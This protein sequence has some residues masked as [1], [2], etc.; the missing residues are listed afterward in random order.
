VRRRKVRDKDSAYRS[1]Q[2]IALQNAA[3]S[4]G[5]DLGDYYPHDQALLDD[6]QEGVGG[7]GRLDASR[8]ELLAYIE[9][10]RTRRREQRRARGLRVV[11][12]CLLV[13]AVAL[14]VDDAEH[15][16]FF[17][18]GGEG[19]TRKDT[20]NARPRLPPSVGSERGIPE[21]IQTSVS[22]S[23]SNGDHKV[24]YVAYVD[25]FGDVCPTVSLVDGGI[26][27]QP[28]GGGCSRLEL[29]AETLSHEPAMLM[30]S[31]GGDTYLQM[32]GYA[33]PDL[34]RLIVRGHTK[35]AKVAISRAW[36]PS[37]L[38]GHRALSLKTFLVRIPFDL[39][40]DPL[41]GVRALQDGSLHLLGEFAGGRLRRVKTMMEIRAERRSHP[42]NDQT[43]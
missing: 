22:T 12:L 35:G 43:G 17:R 3:D 38:G 19:N 28:S 6:L 18:D 24:T 23:L 10:R 30:G 14:V 2:E 34:R 13:A 8:E 25:R 40:S 42:R 33:R 16:G 36:M 5:V 31:S 26:M 27:R 41:A 11:A 21:L 20:R 29:I 9:A 37:K 32:Q 7:G 39:A 1:P 15:V 4:L